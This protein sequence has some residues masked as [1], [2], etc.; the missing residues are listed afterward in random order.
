MLRRLFT[1]SLLVAVSGGILACGGAQTSNA[2]DTTPGSLKGSV[3]NP[4]SVPLGK[5][6]YAA[7]V[8][9][10]ASGFSVGEN[11]AV[12][13]TDSSFALDLVDPPPASALVPASNVGGASASWPASTKIAVGTV[14]AYDDSNGNA[15]L[16]LSQSG[17]AS[18]DE[19]VASNSTQMLVYIDGP[20]PGTEASQGYNLFAYGSDCAG[21]TLLTAAG[22]ATSSGP[23]TGSP[24]SN[25]AGATLS[26]P[27]SGGAVTGSPP[28]DD[29]GA[30][31][32]TP[33]SS[34]PVTGSPPSGGAF[35]APPYLFPGLCAVPAGAVLIEVPGSGSTTQSGVTAVGTSLSGSATGNATTGNPSGPATGTTSAGTS[36]SSSVT[37]TAT[38]GNPS[39]AGCG[40]WGSTNSPIVLT[41]GP[42][43]EVPSSMC[44]GTELS[45]PNGPGNPVSS[46]NGVTPT[47]A[48]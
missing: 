47:Q 24:P 46:L 45:S 8:W 30:T 16:D 25:G 9:H 43:P 13:G 29:A 18:A 31:L 40:I 1:S 20:L 19:I 48:P 32:S 7:V 14:V 12:Q 37:G 41:V 11:V 27:P 15:T 23:V 42:Y 39:G 36:L 21:P 3:T 2:G 33:P 38:T 26:T 17:A 28:G 4:N 22:S 35:G 5:S 34:G 44:G 6:I 10:T